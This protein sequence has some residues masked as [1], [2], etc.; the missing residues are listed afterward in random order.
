MV[1]LREE[2]EKVL[3]E[4]GAVSVGF[5][6]KETLKGG[7]PTTDMT[8]VMPEAETVICFAV[9]LD[10]SK[11]R[12][13][14][15]KNLPRG[16]FDHVIDRGDVYLKAH[17]F[18]RIASNFLEE[19]GH[20][21]AP[22]LNNFNYREEDPDWR[23]KMEPHLAL[24][25]VAARSGVGSI[26]WS[27]NILVKGYGAAI[28]LGAVVTSVKLEPTE[29]IPPEDSVCTMCK[30][31]V[32]A[33]AFRMF[34][35]KEEELFRLGGHTFTFAKRI[36]LLRCYTVCGHLSGLDKTRRWSTWSPGRTQYP[37]TEEET[38]RTYVHL[39]THPIKKLRLKGEQGSYAESKMLHDEIAQEF[40]SSSENAS[41]TFTEDFIATCG[42]CHL[43]CWGDHDE[44]LENSKILMNSGCVVSNE[45]GDNVIVTSDK[46]KELEKAGK[47]KD[48]YQES[49][50]MNQNVE[51]GFNVLLKKLRKDQETKEK[52]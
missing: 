49:S 27:G 41:S 10:K 33:C 3:L 18:A 39:F 26:G 19:K 2:V 22:V 36:N 24:R 46:A 6:T 16:R 17:K 1:N 47:L 51:N 45:S 52:R 13:Y 25:M 30:M 15:G 23:A 28:L 8:Y 9:P 5:A 7:P 40:I 20:E 50:K 43:I 29:S 14:L 38:D 11:I 48:P 42:N 44:T 35:N 21:S 31:C 4:Q 12:P 32:Q 34:S 37:E